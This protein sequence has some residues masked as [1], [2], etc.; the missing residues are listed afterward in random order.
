VIGCGN[1]REQGD[2]HDLRVVVDAALIPCRC[3][4]TEPF[5]GLVAGVQRRPGGGDGLFA[6]R[7][8][9][10]APVARVGAAWYARF[11]DALANVGLQQVA[12][13]YPGA[14]H[15]LT[16][17]LLTVNGTVLSVVDA[18]RVPVARA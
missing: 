2:E 8:T 7:A 9:P 10:A 17:L 16:L 11:Q 14:M 13:R 5:Q 4:S 12:A 1:K 18:I 6:K 15:T 3:S